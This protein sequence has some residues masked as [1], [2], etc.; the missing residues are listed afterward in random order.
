MKIK[1]NSDSELP[2]N[3]PINIPTMTIVVKQQM[4]FTSF[5]RRMSIQITKN[6][7][8]LYFDGMD[9]PEGIEV[10]IRSASKEYDV[11][12]YWYLLNFTFNF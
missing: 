5:F 9:V 8:M 3:K 10:K 7:K 4:L 11:C 6:I 12:Y 1:I 2:L